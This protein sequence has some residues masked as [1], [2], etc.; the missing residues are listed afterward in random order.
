MARKYPIVAT[1]EI[2]QLISCNDTTPDAED[3]EAALTLQFK[4]QLLCAYG[5]L[6]EQQSPKDADWERV[7]HSGELSQAVEQGFGSSE[8]G[9]PE[10][11]VWAQDLKSI[12]AAM[13]WYR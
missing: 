7:I 2:L 3:S 9:P 4:F 8:D 13:G 11:L 5:T 1:S 6:H 10:V 12:L